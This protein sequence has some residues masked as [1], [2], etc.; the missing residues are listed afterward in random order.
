MARSFTDLIDFLL[1]EIA[2]CGDQG[3]CCAQPLALRRFLPFSSF[4]FAA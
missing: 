2:L 4:L 3:K 1:S